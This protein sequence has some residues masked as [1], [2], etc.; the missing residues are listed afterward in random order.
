MGQGKVKIL[1]IDDDINRVKLQPYLDCF[2]DNGYEVIGVANP[3]DVENAIESHR[4]IQCIILDVSMPTGEN[5]DVNES[6]RGM[7]TGLLVLKKL[8][9]DV[10]LNSVKKIVFTIVSDVEVRDYCKIN[11]IACFRKQDYLADNF[12]KEVKGIIEK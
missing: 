7:R 8:N 2:E 10:S 9:A 3:D 5:I 1:W 6:K 11:K 4:N 12:F